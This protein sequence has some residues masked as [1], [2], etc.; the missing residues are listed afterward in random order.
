M[1]KWHLSLLLLWGAALPAA[2][3]AW[4][5]DSC[6]LAKFIEMGRAFNSKPPENRYPIHLESCLDTTGSKTKSSTS[7]GTS[8]LEHEY[9]RILKHKFS[10]D[11]ANLFSE[12]LRF[13]H[14]DRDAKGTYPS[15]CTYSAYIIKSTSDVFNVDSLKPILANFE[16]LKERHWVTP[17]KK[18]IVYGLSEARPNCAIDA[19]RSSNWPFGEQVRYTIDCTVHNAA[20]G[21]MLSPCVLNGLAEEETTNESEVAKDKSR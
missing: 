14:Y 19:G 15:T 17:N 10:L 3:I 1:T 4:F 16:K 5:K 2:P 13:S 11:S 18:S 6:V 12:E 9:S 8:I 7:K 21:E 20:F